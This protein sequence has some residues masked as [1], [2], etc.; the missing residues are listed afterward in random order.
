MAFLFDSL[1]ILSLLGTTLAY[2]PDGFVVLGNKC[3]YISMKL[4]RSLVMSYLKKHTIPNECWTKG[5]WTAINKIG[6][7]QFVVHSSNTTI[8]LLVWGKK[9]PGKPEQ[10][11]V[12]ACEDSPH[13]IVYHDVR[14]DGK[15]WV[16]CQTDLP[17][18]DTQPKSDA[19]VVPWQPILIICI[20][21]R[22]MCF[23]FSRIYCCAHQFI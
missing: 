7:K 8:P 16:I 9:K 12:A 23:T 1:C 17:Q 13:G 18:S 2:C 15:F 6:K 21:F 5:V 22:A 19:T 10:Q 4:E 14:C 3:Y 20:L 11:C